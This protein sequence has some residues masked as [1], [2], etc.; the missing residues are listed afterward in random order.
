MDPPSQLGNEWAPLF[1][2]DPSFHQGHF[3]L[4]RAGLGPRV[5]RLDLWALALETPS[6]GLR[7]I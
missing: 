4:V 1:P 7:V 3:E 5:G 2:R 6:G